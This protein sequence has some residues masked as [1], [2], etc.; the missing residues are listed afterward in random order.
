MKNMRLWYLYDF[1]NSFASVVLIFYYPLILAEKNASNAWI[2]I[3]ASIAT[4]VLLIILPYLGAYSDKMNRRIFFIKIASVCMVLSL[5]V[6]A[7]LTQNI[8]T[9]ST[10]MLLLLSFFYILFQICFQGSYVFYSAM[11]REMTSNGNNP[12]V[13]GV[14]LGFGQLGN[15]IAL[16]MIGPIIGSPFIIIGLSGKPLA[17]F[18]GGVLFAIISIPFFRQQ[19]NKNNVE[20]LNFSYREFATVIFSEK[21]IRYFLIGFSLLAD[22]ILTFQLYL[23]LYVTKIFNFSDK[24]VS[25]A[26]MAGLVF[27]VVGGFSA[28]HFVKKLKSEDR[29]IILASIFYA[30]CF[31]ILAIVPKIPILVFVALSLA[32]L[33]YGILF[34]LARSVYSAITPEK[35]QGEFFS[36]FT[37]F[38]R[39]ASVIGPLVWLGTFYLLKNFGEDFQ[40]R[41]S[42][43]L[44]VFICVVGIYFLKKSY[45]VSSVTHTNLVV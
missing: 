16:G 26:G 17:F 12:K 42:M 15:A 30:I 10:V 32:G 5:F 14:G 31:C 22:S 11:L 24:L 27:A 28:H 45:S 4:L 39:M 29:T 23:T 25:Y 44:L 8:E 40:Y 41:G 18:L 9:A 38:E 3:S 34:S 35:R 21:R 7:F 13:S 43:L 6:L 33:S 2:G 19:E 37:V 1:A 20:P 36:I